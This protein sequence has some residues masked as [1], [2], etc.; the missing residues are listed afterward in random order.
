[1]EKPKVLLI[2]DNLDML[3]IGQ[4]IFSR[5]GYNFVSAR[6]GKEG[7]E[8]IVAEEPDVIIL[9]YMLPDING[10]QF[11]KSVATEQEFD[12]VRNTPIVILTARTN[13]IEDLDRCFDLGL[14]AFLNK[15]FGHRELVNVIDNI[16]RIERVERK[17]AEE[18]VATPHV[19]MEESGERIDPVWFEDLQIAA[20]T[21]SSLYRD[22]A[23]DEHKNLTEEQ[24][25]DIQAIYRSSQN[26]VK[27]ISQKS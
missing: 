7:L 20:G 16:I 5:A 24:K 12:K 13:Y 18:K 10:T 25:L 9:D 19:E 22:L 3:L 1:M 6:T 21:I 14:R 23:A 26:L 2:D 15:P 4:R 27:L 11:I 8:K 17:K